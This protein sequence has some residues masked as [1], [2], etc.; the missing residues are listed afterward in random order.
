MVNATNSLMPNFNDFSFY[1]Y[2]TEIK[3]LAIF[4]IGIFLY[5]LFVFK[6]YKYLARRDLLRLNLK[7]YGKGFSGQFKTFMM[8]FFNVIEVMLLI[9]ILILFWSAIIAIFLVALSKNSSPETILIVSVAIVGAVRVAAYYNEELSQEVAKLIPFTV[10]AVFLM[11]FSYFSVNQSLDA[12]KNMLLSWESLL[13]Y[14]LF[15]IIL[16][17]VLRFILFSYTKIKYS[18]GYDESPKPVKAD[19]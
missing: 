2:L 16:E 17:A 1:S 10:L 8:N 7:D 3:P 19:D 14:L 5:A 13:Y 11:D 4:I 15:V 18:V 6:F 12:A 9:P